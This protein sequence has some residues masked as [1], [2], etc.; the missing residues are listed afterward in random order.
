MAAPTTVNQAREAGLA[1]LASD[2][3]MV[4]VHFELP[5]GEVVVDREGIVRLAADVAA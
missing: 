5:F 1:I 4:A 3:R 2:G